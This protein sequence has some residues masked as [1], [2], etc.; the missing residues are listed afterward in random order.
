MDIKV[1]IVTCVRRGN[2]DR[3][4]ISSVPLDAY[5]KC[6]IR[7]GHVLANRVL[8]VGLVTAANMDIMVLNVN[9][10]ALTDVRTATVVG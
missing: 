3:A 1:H 7:T 4:A 5:T 10:T 9:M 2:T 8:P 6:A